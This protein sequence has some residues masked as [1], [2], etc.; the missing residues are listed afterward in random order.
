MARPILL[1][2]LGQQAGWLRITKICNQG[3]ITRLDL[4]GAF[5][6]VALRYAIC[7]QKSIPWLDGV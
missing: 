4:V 3:A 6:F 2:A 7:L 1:M 5:L